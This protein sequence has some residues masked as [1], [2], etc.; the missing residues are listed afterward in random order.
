[1]S[2]FC[3][4]RAEILKKMGLKT[5]K[6]YIFLKIF[7]IF[8]FFFGQRPTENCLGVLYM[9]KFMLFFY[10]GNEEDVFVFLAVGFSP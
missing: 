2:V 9:A 5:R 10:L 4:V 1:M 6:K 3:V 7:L 8:F